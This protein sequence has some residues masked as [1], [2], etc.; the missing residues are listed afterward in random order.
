MQKNCLNNIK[1]YTTGGVVNENKYVGEIH[2]SINTY[3]LPSSMAR[4]FGCYADYY[5]SAYGINDYF[6]NSINVWDMEDRHSFFAKELYT[7]DFKVRTLVTAYQHKYN[8]LY[9]YRPNKDIRDLIRNIDMSQVKIKVRHDFP[10]Q[11]VVDMKKDDVPRIR[12][13]GVEG[14]REEL[15]S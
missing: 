11:V 2:S 9:L 15:L 4:P 6:T 5:G 14:F 13:H 10:S 1:N 12:I 3:A 8:N 7:F